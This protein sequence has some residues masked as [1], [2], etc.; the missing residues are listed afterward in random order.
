MIIRCA[1]DKLEL[2]SDLKPHPKNPN[3]HGD[4]QIERLAKILKYQGWRSPVKVSR[5]S[6]FVVSGHG[7]IEAARLNGWDSVPVN[8]QDY[9]SDDQEFADLASDN[10]IAEWAQL[11]LGLINFEL[12][13]FD[14]SFDV[15]LFG[16]KNFEI[17]PADKEPREKKPKV[18]PKCSFEF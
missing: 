6:G 15:E 1:H 12:Q 10:S 4:E 16:L 11:D 5:R 8:Y 17:E 18:C 7:R 2:I 9:E 13:N 14:P 3:K